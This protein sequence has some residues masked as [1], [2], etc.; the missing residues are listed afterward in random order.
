MKAHFRMMAAY[1]AWANRRLHDAADRLPETD[2][3]ADLGAFF[4]SVHGTLNHLLVGDMLWL[5]RFRGQP[6][7]ALRLDQ[8]LHEDR[9]ALRA[10]RAALDAE[11]VAFAGGLTEADIEGQIT[12]S[13]ITRPETVTEPTAP[14]LI[15][16]F[17]HQ[18]H[19]RGQVHAL[20]TRLTGEAPALD[21]I[22][23]LREAA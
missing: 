5:A 10:A 21:L 8:I 11:I 23:Y 12:Y 3:R 22:Y 9:A 4:K 16:F 14:A 19:H 18:T 7:P 20:L 15:H 1:N 13:M 2:Y 6:N 17:N